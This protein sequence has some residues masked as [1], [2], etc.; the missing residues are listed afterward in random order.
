MD[1]HPKNEEPIPLLHLG[2]SSPPSDDFS[3]SDDSSSVK[4]T[5]SISFPHLLYFIYF[6]SFWIAE[7]LSSGNTWTAAAHIITGVI[8]SGVLSLA[9]S[10]AQLGWIWGPIL[11][12][13]FAAVTLFSTFLICNCYRSP[14]PDYGPSRNRSYISAVQCNLGIYFSFDFCFCWMSGILRHWFWMQKWLICWVM[15]VFRTEN[16]EKSG[17]W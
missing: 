3:D 8:G 11:M 5:G 14:D 7:Y 9:W 12:L 10:M 1:L 17:V 15:G 13:L 2:L 4:R 6:F 16:C